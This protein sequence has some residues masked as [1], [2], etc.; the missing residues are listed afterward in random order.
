LK[1]RGIGGA[2]KSVKRNGAD[3]IAAVSEQLNLSITSLSE[4]QP[5]VALACRVVSHHSSVPAS[6]HAATF[7]C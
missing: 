5:A 2:L 4:L 6:V 7:L 1:E 3:A